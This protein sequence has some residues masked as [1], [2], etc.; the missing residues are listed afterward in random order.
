MRDGTVEPLCRDEVI[1]LQRNP[2][3]ILIARASGRD[4]GEYAAW[5]FNHGM[6]IV[7]EFAHYA[8]KGVGKK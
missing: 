6:G 7:A 1:P 2:E 4:V 8:K 3:L 5:S